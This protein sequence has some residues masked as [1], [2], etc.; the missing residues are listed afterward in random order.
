MATAVVRRRSSGRPML[1]DAEFGLGVADELGEALRRLRLFE[2]G[3]EGAPASFPELADERARVVHVAFE[4]E[5]LDLVGDRERRPGAILGGEFEHAGCG[6]VIGGAEASGSAGADGE[7]AAEQEPE[8]RVIGD[9]GEHT[10]EF[11]A[12]DGD[13]ARRDGRV[14]MDLPVKLRRAVVFPK[15]AKKTAERRGYLGLSGVLPR[16]GA[17]PIVELLDGGVRELIGTQRSAAFN[18]ESGGR[19]VVGMVAA[20]ALVWP[21]KGYGLCLPFRRVFWV[22]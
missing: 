2:A 21:R 5:A 9:G 22:G 7:V 15:P 10:V 13:V 4:E 19:F 6:L 18:D 14:A 16:T 17:E 11:V 3:E 20:C 8:A 12:V 1:G